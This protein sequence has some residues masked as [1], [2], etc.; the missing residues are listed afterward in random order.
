MP[1]KTKKTIKE[2]KD[3]LGFRKKDYPTIIIFGAIII[4]A[5]AFTSHNTMF[6]L[7]AIALDLL[8]VYWLYRKIRKGKKGGK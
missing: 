1:R 5:L 7:G 8:G 4:N 3:I 2:D 6:I